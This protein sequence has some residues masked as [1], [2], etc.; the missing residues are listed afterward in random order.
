MSELPADQRPTRWT[1]RRWM[2]LIVLMA[3]SITAIAIGWQQ[4]ISFETLV[5]RNDAIHAFIMANRIASVAIYLAIY[6]VTIALSLPG[7]LVLTMS[8]GFLFGGLV[9][10]AGAVVGATA[11]AV[12]LFVVAKSA[13]GEH[14][15]RRAG[16]TAE[17]ARGGL[18]R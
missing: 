2:P 3:L 14:L 5:R 7:G 17:R 18:P 11:G 6:V 4:K 13:F 16:P 1:L 12:I 8:G 9:G 15:T 10:G